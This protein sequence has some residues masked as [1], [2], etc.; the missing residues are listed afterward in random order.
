LRERELVKLAEIAAEMAG[1]LRERGVPEPA[2]S[3]AAETGIAVYRVAFARWI[4]EPGRPNLPDIL[5][6]TMAELTDVLVGR[7]ATGASPS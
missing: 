6:Q 3:L 5:H 2:A 1:A 4:D 7:V